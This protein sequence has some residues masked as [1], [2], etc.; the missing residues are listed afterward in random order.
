MFN[1]IDVISKTNYIL[2]KEYGVTYDFVTDIEFTNHEYGFVI[3]SDDSTFKINTEH[4]NPDFIAKT[5]Y[6]SNRYLI[7]HTNHMFVL[8]INESLDDSNL[9]ECIIDI[10]H[11]DNAQYK[12][13]MQNGDEFIIPWT[14]GVIPNKTDFKNIVNNFTLSH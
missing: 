9:I 5:I 7:N 8:D 2:K 4:M 11:G 14:H 12:V 1:K 10:S 6:D 13:F 3:M